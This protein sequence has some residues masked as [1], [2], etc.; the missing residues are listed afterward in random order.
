MAL[1]QRKETLESFV[2]KK[3]K[4]SCQLNDKGRKAF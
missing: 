4:A 1:T 3:L 2:K